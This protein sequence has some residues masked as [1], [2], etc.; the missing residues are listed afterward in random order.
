MTLRQ[1]PCAR[2][3]W[4]G[5]GWLVILLARGVVAGRRGQRWRLRRNQA[6]DH[7]VHGPAYG[8]RPQSTLVPAAAAERSRPVAARHQLVRF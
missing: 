6:D 5:L 1:R 3:S 7:L 2:H 4:P 8:V